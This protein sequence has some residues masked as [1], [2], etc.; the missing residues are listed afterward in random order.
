MC[1]GLC[2]ECTN[3]EH[4]LRCSHN[5]LL[6]NGSCL[7]SCPEGFFENHDNTCGSCFPQ[8]KTCVG[9][10]SSD[11]ASCRSNSFLHDGKCVYRCPK[12]LYG[13]QG[14]RSCKT[15]PSGCASCMG[16][17]CI[18]CSDGWRM[19]GIHCVAQPTQCSILAKGVRHQAAEDQD[20][21]V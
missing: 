14:S 12:G 18:T 20:D 15:C 3:P 17:S 8:C 6:S 21:S 9:G 19:K 13:D 4:C 7:T 5:L 16:D 2:T 1:G 11:C 10:S